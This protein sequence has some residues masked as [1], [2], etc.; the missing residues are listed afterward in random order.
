VLLDETVDDVDLFEGLLDRGPG[1]GSTRLDV[2]GPELRPDA[3]L[4]QSFDVG[5]QLGLRLGDV[6]DADEEIVA[7]AELVR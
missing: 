2:S 7:L 4:A 6:D 1:L 5:V 3:A